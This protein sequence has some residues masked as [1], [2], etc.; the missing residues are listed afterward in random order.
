MNLTLDERL[1]SGMM[2][3]SGWFS[4]LFL[5]LTVLIALVIKP[6]FDSTLEGWVDTRSQDYQAYQHLLDTYGSDQTLMVMFERRYLPTEKLPDYLAF[7]DHLTG[8]PEVM[9]VYDPVQRFLGVSD[10]EAAYDEELISQL[11]QSLAVNSNGL[12]ATLV[13]P[14]AEYLGLLLLLDP[15][16]PETHAAIVEQVQPFFTQRE[17]PYHLGGTVYFAQALNQGLSLDLAKVISLLM[18]IAFL[19]LWQ[20][21]GNLKLVA[22]LFVTMSFV[23]IWTLAVAVC[24]EIHLNL[25]S[26]MI[27]PLVFCVSLTSAIHLFCQNKN[28]VWSGVEAYRHIKAPALIAMLTTALGCVSFIFAPQP[29]VAKM[30]WLLPIAVIFSFVATLWVTPVLFACF[31]SSLKIKSPSRPAKP[32]GRW[33]WGV[34][35]VL[36]VLAGVSASVMSQLKT[37]PDA[38]YFFKADSEFVESYQQIEQNLTGL[39][40]LELLIQSE[41]DDD[42][43]SVRHQQQV[44]QLQRN[45]SQVSG[46]M[47][48]VSVFDWIEKLSL[49]VLPEDIRQSLIS[50]DHSEARVTLRFRNS[51]GFDY[52]QTRQELQAVFDQS[53]HT[54]LKL[55]VTGLVPLILTAQ[56][57][58][59][60]IQ[61]KVF[62]ISLLLLS[63]LMALIFRHIRVVIAALAAN[64][65]PLLL[66]VGVMVALDMA[67]NS[68]NIFVAAVMLGVIVDD[69]IHILYAW[70]QSEN[71][72]QALAQVGSAL[73][74]TSVTVTL[75]FLSLAVSSFVPVI[76]FGVLAAVA[77]SSAYVCDV[78]LLPCLMRRA[79]I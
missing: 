16:K 33:A 3:R 72:D 40:A 65:I 7:I 78:Y 19:M 12:A 45:L 21:L 56:D 59:L 77:V 42:L 75:A 76:Q 8:L 52:H 43:L 18:G 54:G 79:S 73:W 5:L 46:L 32:H 25:L 2:R 61:A 20:Q 17:I 62:F 13:S 60:T 34:S 15:L 38:F 53:E 26:M 67:V 4:G 37:N 41:D 47:N 48:R 70:R 74:I 30:G 31:D 10:L 68:F 50:E 58:L 71:I 57:E 49:A 51:D 36:L 14:D 69:T 9:A 23:L 1:L 11:K 22:A 29:V 35:L 24:L 66:T 55:T 27:F 28:Q 63:L 44:L 39:V 6:G 64:L